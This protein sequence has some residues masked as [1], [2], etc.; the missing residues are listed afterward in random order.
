MAGH[1]NVIVRLV[2]TQDR[3]ASRD[4]DGNIHIWDLNKAVTE[5]FE[6]EDYEKILV[7]R[8]KSLSR[9]VT[10]IALDERRLVMGSIGQL[11]VYDYWT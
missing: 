9:T 5:V 2:L 6:A 3:A 4:L 10:C 11:C 8:V 1:S 7:R